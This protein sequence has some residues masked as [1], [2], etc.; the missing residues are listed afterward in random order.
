MQV[1]SDQA[2]WLALSN[3]AHATIKVAFT[4]GKR[5]FNIMVLLMDKV[6]F[7]HCRNT[8]RARDQGY[9]SY[10]ICVGK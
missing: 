7:G 5:S 3:Q 6:A 2:L 9:P 8:N 1:S 4:K 10:A